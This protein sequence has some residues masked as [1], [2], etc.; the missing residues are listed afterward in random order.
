MMTRAP[1]TISAQAGVT[2]RVIDLHAGTWRPEPDRPA[3]CCQD[4]A[5]FDTWVRGMG[6]YASRPFLALYAEARELAGPDHCMGYLNMV[7][8]GDEEHVI[9]L[10]SGEERDAAIARELMHRLG[11]AAAARHRR[12]AEIRLAADQAAVEAC[13]RRSAQIKLAADELRADPRV[14]RILDDSLAGPGLSPAEVG[15]EL[16]ASMGLAARARTPY[17]AGMPPVADLARTIGLR[18]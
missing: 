2:G 18:S 16:R 8:A 6:G 12:S 4:C 14:A 7:R 13:L 11:A 5:G 9:D 1:A 15:L 17:E 10:A 3:A